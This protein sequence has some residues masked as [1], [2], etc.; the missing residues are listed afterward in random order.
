MSNNGGATF[1][2]VSFASLGL[3]V[4]KVDIPL[5][6]EV[7][8]TEEEIP[9][10]DGSIDTHF[11]YGARLISLEV[12]LLATDEGDYQNKLQQMAKVFNGRAGIKPLVLDRMTGKRWMC[13]Y[14]GNIPIERIA[15]IGTFTL[16]FKA[17]FPFSE[18]VQL[19]T[20]PLQLG[21]GYVL[22]MGLN[23]SESYSYQVSSS[24][25]TFDVYH[26]GT[27]EAHPV[28]VITGAATNLTVTNN[29]TGESFTLT[30][31]FIST[32][33]LEINCEPLQQTVLKNGVNATGLI[34]GVFPRL[35]E[36][37]NS[38]TVTAATPDLE[39][40]FIFRHTYLY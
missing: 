2:G 11:C 28:I 12:M 39:V 35:V 4:T 7:R 6:P 14:A 20:T 34:S 33:V 24:P 26:A 21:Q 38:I 16:P 3:L 5:L 31:V 29:T 19:S 32:D 8:Q 15:T 22:G 23:L 25:T 37:E 30:G 10:L 36:G 13:K 9:G 40:V 17:F 27:H 1:G 18:S